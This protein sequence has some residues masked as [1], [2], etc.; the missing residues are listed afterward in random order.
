MY[1]GNVFDMTE[2]TL[3]AATEANIDAVLKIEERSFSDPWTRRML[4][5]ELCE[6]IVFTLLLDG[7]TVI[8]YSILDCRVFGEAEL[9]N[10][11]ISPDYRGRGLSG[12]LMDKMISDAAEKQTEVIFLEVREKNAAARG[13]Y[14]KYGFTELTIRK[15]YYKNPTEDAIIM[16][17]SV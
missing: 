4:L 1:K 7:E 11:A 5:S 15:N 12:L 13:L 10:I 9:H 16:Q 8:G 6:G 14:K 3:R 2:F 17:R